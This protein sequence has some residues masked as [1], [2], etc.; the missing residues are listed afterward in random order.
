ML[1][2]HRTATSYAFGTCLMSF[3]FIDLPVPPNGVTA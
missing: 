2:S 3:A 1:G